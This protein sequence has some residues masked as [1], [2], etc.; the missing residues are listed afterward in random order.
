MIQA[1]QRMGKLSVREPGFP[2]TSISAPPVKSQTLLTHNTSP[3]VFRKKKSGLKHAFFSASLEA[4]L[5]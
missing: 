1:E 2:T 4:E 3:N 5:S